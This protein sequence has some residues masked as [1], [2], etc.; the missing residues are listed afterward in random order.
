M[1][2]RRRGCHLNEVPE[3]RALSLPMG[4]SIRVSTTRGWTDASAR[5]YRQVGSG[6]GNSLSCSF[7]S[8]QFPVPVV[9]QARSVLEIGLTRWWPPVAPSP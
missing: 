7:L 9:S 1:L 8:Q 3:G 6:D 5:A 2:L 4:D